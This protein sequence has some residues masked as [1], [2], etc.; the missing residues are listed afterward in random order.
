M[1]DEVQ[2]NKNPYDLPEIPKDEQEQP[3]WLGVLPSAPRWFIAVGGLQFHRFTDPPVGQDVDS[4]ITQRAFSKGAVEMLKPSKAQS[5]MAAMKAKVV[6]FRG[7]TGSGDVYD[8]NHRNYTRLPGDQ[9]LAMHLYMV[10]LSEETSLLR[11][12]PR[13]GYPRSVYEMAG[14]KE[15]PVV[16][17]RN[18]KAPQVAPGIEDLD[19]TPASQAEPVDTAFGGRRLR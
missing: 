5:I 17:A 9:P 11:E 8:I 16:P 3:Y 4:G 2:A 1:S 19:T 13:L 12:S 7:S 15:K 6:R 14:G 18:P 10:P